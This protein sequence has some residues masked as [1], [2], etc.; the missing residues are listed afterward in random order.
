MIIA[1]DQ[2]FML[3]TNSTSYMFK[4][5]EHGL[6]L[7]LYYGASLCDFSLSEQLSQGDQLKELAKA[8]E[9]KSEF[10]PGNSINYTDGQFS[11]ENTNLEISGIGKG[12]L[13]TPYINLVF[14]DGSNSTDF[15][16]KD[17]KTYDRLFIPK[18]SSFGKMAH[19]HNSGNQK[20]DVSS[21]VIRLKDR[22][23]PIFIDLYYI[24]YKDSDCIVRYSKIYN[25]SEKP[26]ILKSLM[27]TQLSLSADTFKHGKVKVSTFGGAWIRE[28]HKNDTI[29]SSGK[30]IS[31]SNTGTSSNRSNSLILVS[32]YDTCQ[33]SG[34]CYGFNLMYSG[35]HYESVEFSTYKDIVV[36]SGINPDSFEFNLEADASF[37]SPEAIMTFSNQGYNSLSHNFHNFVREHVI[38]PT[39]AHKTR[40]ILVNSWEACYFNINHMRLLNLARNAKAVGAELFVM[41]DGWFSNRDDDTSSLGDWEVNKKKLP[42]GLEGLAKGI[43]DLGLDFGIWIEPE[44]ISQKSK[45]Y[46]A[47]PDWAMAIKGRDHSSGRNQMMLDLCNPEVVDYLIETFSQLLS[48]PGINYVKWDM[49]RIMSDVYSPYLAK[50]YPDQRISSM[51]PHLY[52]MGLYRLASSLTQAFPKIL[53]EG[54]A[55]GGNRFDLGMLTFF[56]QIWASDNTDAIARCHIQEGL[57]YGYPLSSYTA[58]V[59]SCPNHQTLRNV[60]LKTRFNVADFANM[61]LEINVSDSNSEEFKTIRTEVEYYK[62]FRDLVL[63]GDFYRIDQNELVSGNDSDQ[64][65][66]L[67]RWQLVSK[68]KLRS[69]ALIVQEEVRP[70]TPNLSLKLTGLEPSYLYHVEN[71]DEKYNIKNFGDLINTQVPVHIKK[72]SLI[73]NAIS[74]FVTMPGEV[75]SFNL[76]GHFLNTA[77]IRLKEAYIATGYNDQVRYFQDYSSRLYEITKKG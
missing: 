28:M 23:K 29:L 33:D 43:H 61:G 18:D 60:P 8:L 20:E 12:S 69:M 57:S 2:V 64:S 50:K 47:H 73:H 72:D 27:S 25:K 71:M 42:F 63:D 1:K 52:V 5:D 59:S 19:S 53:F 22:H 10:A 67:H 76:Y 21:L 55:A 56:P 26:V 54:C 49:N 35:N 11:L 32:D 41:D 75:E 48:T 17:Y 74:R 9:R 46:Q 44:M 16:F 14:P 6:L 66:Y 34:K 37:E 24:V 62:K 30:L 39:F 77:S 7:H 45:L 58:H 13:V 15:I 31:A 51:V 4:I 36:S 65:G 70:N 40:P 68:D 3:N 38:N